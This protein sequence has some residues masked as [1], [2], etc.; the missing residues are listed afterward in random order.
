MSGRLL[1]GPLILSALLVVAGCGRSSHEPTTGHAAPLATNAA[2]L[3]A[4]L[5]QRSAET[6]AEAA[7]LIAA[8]DIEVEPSALMN[9]LDD[10]NPNVRRYCATALGRRRVRAAVRPLFEVLRDD[11]WRVRAE[12][13]TALGRIGD[14]RAVAWLVQ[15]LG[16]SD[17]YVRFCAAAALRD[18]VN[19]SHRELLRRAYARARPV[20]RPALAI[21]LGQLGEP[22]ALDALVSVT[23]TNDAVLRRYAIEALGHYPAPV[24]TN[25]L[26]S[27]LASEDPDVRAEAARAWQRARAAGS[28]CR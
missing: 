21:A 8:N 6:R 7:R 9:G 14:G 26:A 15:L 5:R 3:T 4:A 22:A 10:P 28:S 23:Q 13:A 12:A 2:A 24:V 18:V 19:E 16:D 25:R 1:R 20:E 11:D 27:L 17:A